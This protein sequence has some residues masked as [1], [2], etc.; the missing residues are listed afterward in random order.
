MNLAH[1]INYTLLKPTLTER[2]IIDFCYRA[3]ENRFYSVCVNS[4]Y[5]PLVKQLLE[6][7]T[8]KISSVVG[9]PLGAAS[10]ASKVFEAKKAVKDGA[11]EIEMVIN[12]GFLKSKNHVSVLKDIIDVKLAIED[13]PLKVI[14]EISE[15]NKN[16]VIKISEICI[17]ANADYIKTSSGFSKNGATLTDVKIIKKTVRNAI[18]ICAHDGIDDYDTALKF[19][20]AGADRIGTASI[21]ETIDRTLQIRNIKIYKQYIETLTSSEILELSSIKK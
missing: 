13:I 18:K 3:K 21:F 5:V 7:T 2:D 1:Y 6:N 16:E 15:L 12:L 9:F 4:S 20:D 11:D 10:T 14:I 17:D 19:I 8:I